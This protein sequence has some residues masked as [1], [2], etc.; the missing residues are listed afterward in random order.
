MQ[1]SLRFH[2]HQEHMKCKLAILLG[3]AQVQDFHF[4]HN[5]HIALLIVLILKKILHD[6]NEKTPKYELVKDN[7]R[8]VL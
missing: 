8:S 1:K 7:K 4:E 2:V 6:C 5:Q 3:K